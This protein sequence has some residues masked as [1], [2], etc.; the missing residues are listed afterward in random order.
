MKW[1]KLFDYR[2]IAGEDLEDK[3][4]KLTIKEIRK[5]E[6]NTQAGKE[7]KPSI[8]FKETTKMVVMNKTNAKRLEI[9]LGS[10][11][12]DDWI[13]KK[14]TLYAEKINAFGQETLAVRVKKTSKA[15]NP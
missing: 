12:I 15:L 3:E 2:F 1:R 10:N 6:V 11:D 5:E 14:I 7:M 13:G 4:V 8:I 9:E